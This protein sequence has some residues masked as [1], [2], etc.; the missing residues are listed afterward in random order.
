MKEYT[1]K[2]NCK[3]CRQCRFPGKFLQH[4]YFPFNYSIWCFHPIA[5][6][7]LTL[8]NQLVGSAVNFRLTLHSPKIPPANRN[9]LR[10]RRRET[11][12]E[13]QR[14]G[15][16]G[17]VS[18]SLKPL[19]SLSQGLA[20]HST[21]TLKCLLNVLKKIPLCLLPVSIVIIKS[22]IVIITVWEEMVCRGVCWSSPWLGNNIISINGNENT[23]S[24]QSQKPK[25][26]Q[27][28]LDLA[29]HTIPVFGIVFLAV[30]YV[31]HQFIV[32]A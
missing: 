32:T 30:L 31:M 22:V 25:R 13:W 10:S 18:L 9:F 28:M 20:L 7:L 6:V 16:F 27:T 5:V 23:L 26:L 17:H 29:S 8:I 3:K 1:I 19:Q 11:G 12:G 4:L 14:L 21:L 15:K 24:P 2:H